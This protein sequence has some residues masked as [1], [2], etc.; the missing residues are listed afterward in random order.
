MNLNSISKKPFFNLF[1]STPCMGQ[2]I[3]L[4]FND[5][6]QGGPNGSIRLGKEIKRPENAGLKFALNNV[7]DFKEHG[8]HITNILSYADLIQLGGYA[9]IEYCGGPFINFRM[10]REDATDVL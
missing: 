6:I 1:Y 8:N 7:V 9:A 5:A 3:R 10:G 4:A 2:L